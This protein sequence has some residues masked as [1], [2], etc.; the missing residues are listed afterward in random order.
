MINDD[1]Q[2]KPV[3][4]DSI[5]VNI[6]QLRNKL[7]STEEKV[8]KVPLQ[9]SKSKSSSTLVSQIAK[10]LTKADED[11]YEDSPL[12]K[13]PKRIQLVDNIFDTE[14]TPTM[15]LEQL[16]EANQNKVWAWK[17]KDMTDIQNY[18][19]A[20]DDLAPNTLK[21]Q[22]QKLKD[23]DEEE[24]VLES[25]T[26]DKDTEILVQIREEKEQEF[27]KFMSEIH[28]YLAEGPQNIEEV[29]FKK[30]MKDYVDLIQDR[31][32]RS[33]PKV[34]LPNVQLNTVSKMKSSLF[35]ETG[36]VAPKK[37][38]PKVQKLDRSKLEKEFTDTNAAKIKKQD[39]VMPK[40]N[41]SSVKQA[42]ENE[43][44]RQEQQA[45]EIKKD[46]S[47]SL[48]IVEK[49]KKRAQEEKQR[50]LE[51]QL[52]HKLKTITELQDY[53][54]VHESLGTEKIML[55]VRKFKISKGSDQNW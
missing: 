41:I 6:S 46:P 12:N 47:K 4:R 24:R 18:I 17:E 54:L 43:R 48:S 40:Q 26:K 28:S 1:N 7:T 29:E 35:D 23:L 14:E 16:K 33:T 44:K 5:D 49:F 21:A 52:K 36:D 11:D 13:A 19:T 39:L 37:V 2:E 15:T 9:P 31:E 53:I 10:N 30:G 3:R 25:L 8:Q 34:S 27:E 51:H 45:P 50:K 38:S 20:Y 55:A 22:Q 32:E 42:F